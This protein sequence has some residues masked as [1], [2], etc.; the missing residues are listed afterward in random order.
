MHANGVAA[1]A[2]VNTFI[3]GGLAMLVW[4][5][6]DWVRTGKAE[7]DRRPDRRARRP[8]RRDALRRLRA[9]LGG[10]LRRPRGRAGSATAPPTCAPSAA[11]TTRST[12]GACTAS[13]ACS[14]RCC[15]GWFAF[16]SVGGH[17]GLLAGNGKQFGLQCAG[18]A[19][20]VG[21]AFCL[22]FVILKVVDLVGQRARVAPGAA[23]G[24]RRGAPRRNGLRSRLA[25]A[26]GRA[27]APSAP[28]PCAFAVTPAAA[29]AVPGLPRSRARAPSRG[30]RS[31]KGRPGPR[32]GLAPSTTPP[33]A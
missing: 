6:T 26:L 23:P 12:S 17:N 7:H 14:A 10:R 20:A 30:G 8:R 13:A 24:P 27:G 22:S 28:P 25:A 18:V 3:A 31:A 2:F 5:F 16:A 1:Q 19:I 15:V 9:H 4:M 32:T 21:Y 11:G 33:P 29:R